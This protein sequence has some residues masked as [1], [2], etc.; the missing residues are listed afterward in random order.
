ML[1]TIKVYACYAVKIKKNKPSKY[2]N[3]VTRPRCA[4]PESEFVNYKL[5]YFISY[6]LCMICGLRRVLSKI[7]INYKPEMCIFKAFIN[8]K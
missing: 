3:K 4:G 6:L 1:T 8:E 2:L 7:I 5:F